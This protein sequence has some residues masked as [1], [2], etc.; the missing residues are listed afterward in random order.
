MLRQG[1]WLAALLLALYAYGAV[2]EPRHHPNHHPD[3]HYPHKQHDYYD[4]DYSR[5]D[6]YYH[7]CGNKKYEGDRYTYASTEGYQL[8][9][10]SMQVKLLCRCRQSCCNQ[11]GMFFEWG[12]LRI[13]RGLVA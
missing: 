12:I 4:R 3:H 10:E 5:D 6:G 8:D 13:L 9:E 7:V 11:Q 1:T 2:A